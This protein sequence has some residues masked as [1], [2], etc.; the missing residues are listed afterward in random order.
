MRYL[1]FAIK[2]GVFAYLYTFVQIL[3]TSPALLWVKK[4][5]EAE[6]LGQLPSKKLL[7]IIWA[8][9]FF[10]WIPQPVIAASATL[11][12]LERH[13]DAWRWLYFLTGLGCAWPPGAYDGKREDLNRGFPPAYIAL[14]LLDIVFILSYFAPGGIPHFF[15]ELGGWLG[16]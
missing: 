5:I 9:N 15:R 2:L 1:F 8:I 13:P 3:L 4:Q 10:A 7:W 14:T 6:S 16:G 12:M 11:A